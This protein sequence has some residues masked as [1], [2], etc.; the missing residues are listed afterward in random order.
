MHLRDKSKQL[1]RIRTDSAQGRKWAMLGAPPPPL[2][3]FFL[4]SL[5]SVA[6]ALGSVAA[7]MVIHVASPPYRFP[8]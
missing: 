5:S 8:S 7:D 6:F 3:I 4:C 1:P 2:L